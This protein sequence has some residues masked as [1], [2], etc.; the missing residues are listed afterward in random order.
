[1]QTARLF[2][3]MANIE[4]GIGLTI[5]KTVVH[6]RTYH[7]FILLNPGSLLFSA[8]AMGGETVE[9]TRRCFVQSNNKG[10]ESNPG[11]YYT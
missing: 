10:Q 11:P 8:L 7:H 2:R 1:M 5:A 9:V 4:R 6:I 3:G